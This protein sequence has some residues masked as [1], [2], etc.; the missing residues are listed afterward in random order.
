[1]IVA[2]P[3]L[4]PV[5]C[6]CVVGVVAPFAIVKGPAETATFVA[7][8]LAR[9]TVRAVGAGVGS[10]TAKVTDCESATDVVAGTPMGPAD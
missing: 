3:I 7:S 2:F 5:T 4:M 10:V 8:L 6:G 1:M 9:V